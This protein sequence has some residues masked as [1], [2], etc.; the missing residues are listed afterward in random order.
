MKEYDDRPE[1]RPSVQLDRLLLG[2]DSEMDPPD[3]IPNSVVKRLSADDSV[4]RPCKSR[5]SP[6]VL[7]L[8]SLSVR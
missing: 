2:D 8:E 4:V 5:T 3:P 6:G 7:I 1:G